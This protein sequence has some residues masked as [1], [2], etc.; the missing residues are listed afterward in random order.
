VTDTRERGAPHGAWVLGFFTLAT[1]VLAFPLAPSK[2]TTRIPGN[3]GDALLNLWILDW[4]GTHVDDGW[5]R[6]WD[7]TIFSPR[8][9]TLAYSESMLPVALV[10]RALTV[11]VRSDVLAFNLVYLATWVAS[12]WFTYLLARRI[13]RSTGAS[14]VAGL[15]FTFSTPRLVH[16]GFLQLSFAGLLPAIV[17]GV[18]KV[19]DTRRAAWG[20]ALGAATAVLALS[21]SYYGVVVLVALAALLAVMLGLDRANWRALLVPLGAAAAVGAVL[22]A[23]AVYQYRELQE[24]PYFRRDPEISARADDFLRVSPDNYVLTEIEPFS[25]RSK[26]ESATIEQRLFPGAGALVLAAVGVV[27]MW[28][29]RR[30]RA[31]VA[32]LAL[33]PAGLLLLALS[34]GE[35]FAIG[36]RDWRLPWAGIWDAPGLGSVRVP[37]RFVVFPMLVLALVAATGLA[38]MLAR[39]RAPKTRLALVA[40]AV[41][42]VGAES[43]TA[44]QFSRVPDDDASTAV[45]EELDD[46]EPGT[47]VELPLR[48]AEDGAAWALVEMPRQYLSTIDGNERLNGYSGFAPPDQGHLANAL[49]TFP[50]TEALGVLR[51]RDVRYV[52]LRMSLPVGLAP[53]EREGIEDAGLGPY[54]E[55]QAAAIVDALPADVRN[56]GR[57]GDAYLLELMPG[58][59]AGT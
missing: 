4:V 52:V 41:V 9:N 1:L 15:V 57:Y 25:S 23:P 32:L 59:G 21:S 47:V 2:W 12:G 40:A 42:L 48:S 28:R 56:L 6:I 27:A 14:I 46:R 55:E 50:S 39:V 51:A 19:F 26:P 34:F 33:V 45:N 11:V 29:T 58:G 20:A 37:A 16:Y 10:H 31:T 38:A 22:V 5:G 8:G 7:T 49:D 44:L 13:T 36:G 30:R 53:Y 54:S 24:D 18:F 43:A 17:L 35:R 3:H